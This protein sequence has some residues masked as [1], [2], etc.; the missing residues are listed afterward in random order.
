MTEKSC[1][2]VGAGMA[3]LAAAEQLSK[4]GWRIVVLDKGRAPG[5]RMATRQHGATR[6]DHGAQFFTVRHASLES[7]VDNWITGGV[8]KRW[9]ECAG[10]TR[11]CGAEGMSSIARSLAAT[12]DVRLNTTVKQVDRAGPRWQAT[13]S[14]GEQ[15]RGEALLLTAPVP[16]SLGLL[17]NLQDLGGGY[18]TLLGIDYDP[19][20]ALMA[21]FSSPSRIPAPGYL[22]LDD[23]PIAVISDNSQKG[24]S[25][26]CADVTIHST[27]SFAR[28]AAAMYEKDAAAELLKATEPWLG[29]VPDR[30]ELHRWR[31]SLPRTT[32]SEPCFF[33]CSPAAIAIAG[34]AFGG[35]SEEHTSELQSH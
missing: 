18:E 21:R 14:T 17:S 27:P 1:L 11:Y 20:L 23:G 5:G 15:F 35:R 16:Q 12:V 7:A 25:D 13:T 22:R 6:F 29:G 34:D 9:F 10:H 30:W 24:I 33:G 19:C 3:G 4:N 28:T 31:Y 8:V 2:I 32:Y 26:G